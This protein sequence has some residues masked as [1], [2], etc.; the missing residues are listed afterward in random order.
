MYYPTG[1][2]HSTSILQSAHT[3]FWHHHKNCSC[4]YLSQAVLATQ[5]AELESRELSLPGAEAAAAEAGAHVQREAELL[6]RAREGL[7]ADRAVLQVIGAFIRHD[8]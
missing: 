4:L 1:F 2:R 3:L 6:R 5:R 7:E 8:S